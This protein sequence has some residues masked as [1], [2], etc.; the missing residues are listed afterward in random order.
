MPKDFSPFKE[1]SAFIFLATLSHVAVPSCKGVWGMQSGRHTGN[2][3][4]VDLHVSRTGPPLE[5]C[6]HVEWWKEL[7]LFTG[8]WIRTKFSSAGA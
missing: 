3:A 2:L 6:S 8:S 5:T 4:Q 1:T 7:S